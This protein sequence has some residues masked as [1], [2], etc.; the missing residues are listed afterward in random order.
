VA[1]PAILGTHAEQ[2]GDLERAARLL[3]KAGDNAVRQ[4]DDSGAARLFRRALNA[5]AQLYREKKN[6]RL[7]VDFV[8][9]S[10][11]LADALRMGGK[12]EDADLVLAEA[13][14]V[15]EEDPILHSLVLRASAQLRV[16]AGEIHEARG[17]YRKIIALA[18]PRLAVDILT[19]AYLD[20]ATMDLREGAIDRAI[21]E[22]TEAI[23]IITLGEG[24]TATAVP[25]NFWCIL[26][27]LSQLHALLD[28]DQEA[29]DLAIHANR[30]AETIQ[31]QAGTARSCATLAGLY[32]KIGKTLEATSYRQRAL[33]TMRRSGD[34]RDSD[35][36]LR[37]GSSP[38]DSMRRITAKSIHSVR[39][40]THEIG[41]I[42]GLKK[43]TNP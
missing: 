15:S 16:D 28:H 19:D 41:W 9:L 13:S 23:N 39:N 26:L 25:E 30:L 32:K 17:M 4:L 29:I 21:R 27:R 43:A 7:R 3:A 38:R 12:L 40:L 42:E 33:V 22:L 1:D 34:R 24:P 2:A 10:V 8:S 36:L 31:N 20:L 37:S 18:M 6:D 14:P 35:E 5:I 11:C